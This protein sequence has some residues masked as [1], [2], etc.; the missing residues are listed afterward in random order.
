[1]A[2]SPFVIL[3]VEDDDLIREAFADVLAT[4]GRRIVAVGD[5][6]GARQALHEQRVDL[7]IIDIG[8]PGGSGLDI[9]REALQQNPQLPVIVCSGH[10]LRDI[11]PTLGPT[12]HPLRKPIDLDDIESLVDRIERAAQSSSGTPSGK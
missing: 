1:M 10:D 6:A 3:Y 4:A 7:L 8:L 5:G 2:A 12:A 9:A 11:A